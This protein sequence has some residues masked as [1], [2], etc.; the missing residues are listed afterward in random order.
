MALWT[1]F[2]GFVILLQAKHANAE[3]MCSRFI[4]NHE[5]MFFSQTSIH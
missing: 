3:G 1:L 2:A 5:M 4:T